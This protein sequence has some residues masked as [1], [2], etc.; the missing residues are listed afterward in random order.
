MPTYQSVGKQD[1]QGGAAIHQQLAGNATQYPFAES[2]VSV[3]TGDQQLRAAILCVPYQ[4]QARQ[5]TH[6]LCR[7][8][9]LALDGMR[10]NQMSMTQELIAQMLGVRR[11]GVNAAAGKLQDA[12]LIQYGRGTIIV[13]DRIGL[14]ARSCECYETVKQETERLVPAQLRYA[15]EACEAA[16]PVCASVPWQRLTSSGGADG[17]SELSCTERVQTTVAHHVTL[18]P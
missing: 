7:R 1:Q 5:Q 16:L 18:V 13:L 15:H 14:E 12:G 4:C 6:R 17:V 9:L 2:R 10:T 11:E 3:A 8:L